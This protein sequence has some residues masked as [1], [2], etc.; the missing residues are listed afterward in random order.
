METVICDISAL[1]FWRTP[2]VVRLLASGQVADTGLQKYV[3]E[4]TIV[5]LQNELI[6]T[7]P[8]CEPF[9]SGARWRHAGPLAQNLRDIFFALA[10]CLS[11]PIDVLVEKRNAKKTAV[12]QPRY[13]SGDLPPG[14][15]VPITENVSVASPAFALQQ[16]IARSSWIE[17][18]MMANE[19]CGTFSVYECP[20]AIKRLIATLLEDNASRKAFFSQGSWAPCLSDGAI[21][22][23]WTRPALMEPADMLLLAESGTSC[24]GRQRLIEVAELVKPGAASPLEVQAGMLLGLSRHRGGEG[25]GDF[26]FNRRVPLTTKARAL[27]Q[28]SAC[29]CD[30]FYE[31]AQ[32][33]IECQGALIHDNE[34]SFISDFDRSAALQEMGVNVLFASAGLLSSPRRFDAFSDLVAKE[35]DIKRPKQTSAHEIAALKLRAALFSDWRK[36]M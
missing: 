12:V 36:L 10:P 17:G 28:K 27:A 22:D 34:S 33:D 20:P 3:S 14:S 21:S 13:W 8:C 32:L 2:P 23:L 9:V 31:G 18:L 16:V 11:L 25:F 4:E 29:V 7:L 15:I 24:R 19:L 5:R 30:L 26:E 1:R 35:L 6:D